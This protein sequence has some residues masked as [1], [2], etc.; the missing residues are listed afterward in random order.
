MKAG[1]R[2]GAWERG[3]GGERETESERKGEVHSSLGNGSFLLLFFIH[4]G[5][6][7]FVGTP[8]PLSQV[9]W[10]KATFPKCGKESQ[11]FRLFLWQSGTPGRGT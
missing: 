9:L 8:A 4:K 2:K 10:E 3:G 11:I 7:S 6:T 1:M 5:Y